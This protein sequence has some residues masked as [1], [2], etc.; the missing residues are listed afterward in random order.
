MKVQ[1]LNN[2]LDQTTFDKTVS[3]YKD[4]INSQEMDYQGNGWGRL[5]S[6]RHWWFDYLH[7]N[8]I[9]NVAK[10][11]FGDEI[12]PSYSAL[13]YYFRP[14]SVCPIHVD[15][16][17]CRYSLDMVVFQDEMWP[18]YVNFKKI[19][20]YPNQASCYSGSNH[21]HWRDKIKNNNRIGLAFFH[22]TDSDFKG[23]RN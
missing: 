8:Q 19:E 7:S 2:I 17:Q 6:K 22:F 12:R 11:M 4:L 13:S 20:M 21:I 18:I 14:D 23:D 16:P 5:Y 15:R 9:L 3:I 10:R 1:I